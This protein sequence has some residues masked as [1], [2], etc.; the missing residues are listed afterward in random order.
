MVV[1]E[2]SAAWAVRLFDRVG[3]LGMVAYRN[4]FGA[5]VLL[6]VVRPHWRTMT[7]QAWLWTA[8]LGLSLAVMNPL[9]YQ[10]LSRIGL[11][12]A[13]TLEG[14]GPLVLAVALGRRWRSWL[15]AL[16]A[17]G[18]LLALERGGLERL[19][20]LGVVL[21]LAAGA[22][23]AGYIV[24]A[25][26]VGQIMPGISGLT[27]AMTMAAIAVMPMGLLSAGTAWF[28][29]LTM[30]MGAGV[31]VAASS[32]PYGMEMVALKR[33]PTEAFSI[34]MSLTPA[35]AALSGLLFLNQ[36]LTIPQWVG[37]AAVIIASAGAIMTTQSTPTESI[38]P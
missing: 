23:W 27:V 34:M 26:R 2:I 4:I 6:L 24:A 35:I 16:F 22:A 5:L 13:A 18:G 8:A 36:R 9:F 21:A 33:L 25:G 19:D 3:P 10:S 17:F 12:A 20:L 37:V 31:A 32:I 30:L 14:L 15:W 11:G 1:Y 38:A 28:N 7:R 29:P